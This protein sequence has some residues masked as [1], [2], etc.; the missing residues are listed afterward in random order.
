M[1]GILV[2]DLVSS[3]V[4]Y[5]DFD[6]SYHSYLVDLCFKKGMGV[7]RGVSKR[8]KDGWAGNP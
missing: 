2:F 3:D 8:V 6:P 7:R 4:V 1:R 5:Y